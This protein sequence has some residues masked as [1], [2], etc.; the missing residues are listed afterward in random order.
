MHESTEHSDARDHTVCE[1]ELAKL[2]ANEVAARM[3]SLPEWVLIDDRLHRTYRCESFLE[4]ISFVQEMARIAEQ[5]HHH[6][7]FCLRDKRLVSVTIWTHKMD[8]LTP[9]DFDLAAAIDEAHTQLSAE[10]MQ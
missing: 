7:E 6:P 4:S 8:C 2:D 5:I 9:L 3:P 10:V 1:G